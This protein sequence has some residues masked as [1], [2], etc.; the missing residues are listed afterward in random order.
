MNSAL[1]IL[2]FVLA[3]LLSVMLH[4]AGHFFAARKFGM[5]VTEFFVG[6]GPRIWSVIRGE[7]EYGVKAIPAGGY[8]RISGMTPAEELSAEDQPRAFYRAR[9]IHR[10]ITLAAGS[11]IH[12]VIGLLLLFL[13]LFTI[14][15]NTP[16]TSIAQISPCVPSN[17]AIGCQSS[18]LI[19]PAKQAGILVGDKLVAVDGN[20]ISK[21]EDGTKI[22]RSKAGVPTQ[23]I[24]LR[25]GKEISLNLIPANLK[26]QDGSN[27]GFIG[28]GPKIE[29]QRLTF[30]N[31]TTTSITLF[32]TLTK[33]SVEGL[34]SIPSK[35]PT[36]WGQ[37]IDH[38]TRTSEDL[39]GVVGAAR[40]SGQTFSATNYSVSEKIGT[41]L[42]MVASLNIF[43]GLF[44]SLPIPPLD[45]GHIAV[46]IADGI[47]RR[48]A[49]FKG[50][51]E[52]SPIDIARLTPITIVVLT[53][54]ISLSLLLLAADIFNPVR[55]NL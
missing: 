28:I 14:G 33:A 2:A 18:D 29:P 23:L 50:K 15:V 48:W 40:A 43:V 3:L 16:T 22:F 6:F 44:N 53:A 26:L 51:S 54:L 38:K 49:R 17:V 39:V 9:I 21:W 27:R 10:I 34:L 52:P 1:G 37:V 30:W 35:I 13:F 7:T 19:S 32:G 5:K 47:R 55:L 12:F 20:R 4:E 31:S 24:V 45:G 8:V 42:L 11:L 25:D 36:L 41:F 46:A